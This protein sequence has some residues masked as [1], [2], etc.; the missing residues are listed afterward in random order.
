[1]QKLEIHRQAVKNNGFAMF[2]DIV[3]ETQQNEQFPSILADVMN[4]SI[5]ELKAKIA[6]HQVSA[7]DY[8]KALE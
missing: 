6:L 8:F 3:L 7:E 2:T 5:S 1:M 4:I